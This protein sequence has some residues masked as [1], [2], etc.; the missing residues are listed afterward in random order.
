MGNTLLELFKKL[1][2]EFKRLFSL[3]L[4]TDEAGTIDNVKKSIEFKGG[5]LWGL[6]FACLIASIGLNTGS[7]AVIIGAMLISPLMGPIVGIGYSVGTNDFQTLKV[8]FR[9]L[10]LMIVLSVGAATLY[11]MISPLKDAT[12][13]LLSRTRPTIFDVLIAIFGGVIGI[14]ASSRNNRGNAIPGVAIATALMP[15]LCTAGYGLATLQFNYFIGAFY[16]F[17]INSVFIALTTTLIVRSLQF[18]QQTFLDKKQEKRVR[19]L[20]WGVVVLTI[21]P[22]II[23]AWM[24]VNEAVFLRNA[25]QFV[26]ENF[27][28]G[29]LPGQRNVLRPINAKFHRDSS[30]IELTIL[31]DTINADVISKIKADMKKYSGLKRTKLI[32]HQ[33]SSTNG[34][35]AVANAPQQIGASFAYYDNI[36]KQL[37]EVISDKDTKIQQLDKEVRKV[38]ASNSPDVVT[39]K[40]AAF[41]PEVIT[42][43][44]SDVIKTTMGHDS[45][46]RRTDTIPTANIKWSKGE[47]TEEYKSRLRKYLKLE[48]GLDTV[49]VVSY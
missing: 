16:L 11:F 36:I 46:P 38:K 14:V 17:F 6:V 18:P 33:L 10:I 12:S 31:G 30:I 25:N 27:E 41:Y 28:E 1:F 8:S 24:V 42:V 9:N 40:I 4:D 39:Q 49:E 15:P 48:L 35:S 23:T 2:S 37:N 22:S 13:E 19:F 21:I 26:I 47:L 44:I 43:G 45:I 29:A 20:I 3:H 32:V 34:R 5:N 7:T